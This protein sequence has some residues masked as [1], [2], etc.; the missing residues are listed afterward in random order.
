MSRRILA[1]LAIL[2]AG[3]VMDGQQPASHAAPSK[4]PTASVDLGTVS[5][6][7]YRNSFFGFS[8]KVPYGW[9]DRTDGMRADSGD[10]Q[11]SDAGKSAP[12]KG[13]VLL[14]VFERPPEATGSTV[15]SAIVIAAESEASYPGMKDAAQY[16]G[17]ISEITKAN[18]FS[19]VNE[20]YDFPVDAAPIVREDF[21]RDVRGGTMW[22]S[23]LAMLR[24]GYVVSFTFIGGSDDDIT[25]D[26][27]Y[28]KFGVQKT[29]K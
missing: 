21:K 5:E 24:K 1:L 7:V 28:L 18:G 9:V 19:V 12:G 29:G 22:Q 20:T 8:V 23:T 14:A 2:F 27:E 26:L 16:F 17:P 6:G 13:T 4:A 25:R 10:A 3:S 11:K 15:N